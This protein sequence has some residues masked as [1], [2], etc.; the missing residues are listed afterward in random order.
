LRRPGADRARTG[1]HPWAHQLR[2]SAPPR[3]EQR[4]GREWWPSIQPSRTRSRRAH[5]AARSISMTNAEPSQQ[6]LTCIARRRLFF[7]CFC[8]HFSSVLR[9]APV[10]IMPAEPRAS[11]VREAD[12]EVDRPL[13]RR[14]AAEARERRHQAPAAAPE[15]AAATL[16]SRRRT[17]AAQ[18]TFPSARLLPIQS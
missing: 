7:G 15:L 11:R 17:P 10:A 12:V 3:R 8:P 2:K 14:G 18:R 4:L 9:R 6:S 5:G 13:V 16:R 1:T